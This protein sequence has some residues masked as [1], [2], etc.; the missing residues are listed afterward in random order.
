VESQ[1]STQ[2]CGDVKVMAAGVADPL[3]DGGERQ[4][5][6]FGHRQRV[7]VSPQS[8]AVCRVGRADVGHQAA[9]R[10]EPHPDTGRD[11]P[12]RDDGTGANLV[13][14][15]LGV[16]MQVAA[17]LDELV[18]QAGQRPADDCGEQGNIALRSHER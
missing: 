9:A 6:P 10:K 15:Q 11:Q 8:H 4:A 7:Q 1:T 2:H 18:R 13:A 5:G 14:R 12:V 16:G 3:I 17:Q